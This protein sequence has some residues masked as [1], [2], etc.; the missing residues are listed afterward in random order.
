SD[1]IHCVNFARTHNLLLS[2][3]GGG[4]NVA[5]N[6]VCENGLMIDL[7]PLRGIRVDP[8]ARSVRAEPGLTWKE[9]DHETLAFGLVTTG[10]TVSHTGI[11]GL[12]LGG[13]LGWLMSRQG[14]TCDNLLSADIV[15]ADG[16]FRTVSATQNEDLFWALR[17]GGG[18]FGV[19][20]SFE[21]RLHSLNATIVGGMILYPVAQAK[22]VLQF[23]R[24]LSANAPDE[25]TLFAGLLHTPDSVP[26][27]AV[28]PFWTGAVKEGLAHLKPLRE[29]GAPL[30]DLIGEIPYTQQQTLFDAAAPFGMRRYWKAGY[31]AELPD[32]LLDLLIH[33]M[34]ENPSPYSLLLFFQIHGAVTRVGLSET[35]FTARQNQWDVDIISQWQ[36]AGDDE[37]NLGWARNF[38]RQLE[39][40]TRGAYQNHFD[41]DDG[42]ARVR[43]AYGQ[44]YERLAALKRKYDPTNLFRMNNNIAPV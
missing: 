10:G 23:Y 7:S 21:Y 1:V 37:K 36:N 9:L 14:A 17:G 15:T 27:V 13:G 26:V 44:N 40:Y 28:I 24:S 5:G 3:R 34:A 8:D 16:Q 22:E 42:A 35:P 41:A 33:N 39:P 32:E 25:L 30:A 4:H 6:A 18:N 19:V 31:C 12:T 11:A 20:T 29:F 38:W 43:L 2:V